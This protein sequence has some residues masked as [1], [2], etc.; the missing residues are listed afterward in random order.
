MADC[1]KSDGRAADAELRM[2]AAGLVPDGELEPVD[3]A[4][5]TWVAEHGSIP[6]YRL[7]DPDEEEGEI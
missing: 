7:P 4:A 3:A 6:V 2:I 1:R 5:R